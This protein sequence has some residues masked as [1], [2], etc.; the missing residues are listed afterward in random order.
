MG[1]SSTSTSA[2]TAARLF[3]GKPIFGLGRSASRPAPLPTPISRHPQ[4]RPGSNPSSLGSTSNSSWFTCRD[5]NSDAPLFEPSSLGRAF[6]G[7]SSQSEISP[8]VAPR[9]IAGSH[10]MSDAACHSW[11]IFSGGFR[12]RR[13]G[14][15]RHHERRRLVSQ[16]K[17]NGVGVARW[18]EGDRGTAYNA[19]PIDAAYAHPAVQDRHRIAIRPH[20]RRADRMEVGLHGLARK[21]RKFRVGLVRPGR[22]SRAMLEASG[23]V[24]SNCRAKR[25]D[26][27]VRRRSSG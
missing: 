10:P 7:F 2:R 18:D 27:R 16:G 6:P 1:G 13:P 24:A 25:M 8:P 11:A 26:A 14:L 23:S 15:V 9:F 21:G 4:S 17:G 3:S 5:S 19:Q 22:I 20:A 12:R